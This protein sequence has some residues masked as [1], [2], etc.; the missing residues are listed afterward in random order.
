MYQ[1][2][3]V[4]VRQMLQKVFEERPFENPREKYTRG[5]CRAVRMCNLFTVV[6][7]YRELEEASRQV[8]LS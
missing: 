8:P 5:G 7:K 6:Q 4:S 2:A 1:Q 3:R